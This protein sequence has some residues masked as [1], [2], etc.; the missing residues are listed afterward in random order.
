MATTIR[1][2]AHAVAPPPADGDGR[3][4]AGWEEQRDDEGSIYYYNTYTGVS[5]WALPGAAEGAA[6]ESEDCVAA[7]MPDLPA[8]VGRRLPLASLS[9]PSAGAVMSAGAKM[10]A[11]VNAAISRPFGRRARGTAA[12]APESEQLG[13]QPSASAAPGEAPTRPSVAPALSPDAPLGVTLRAAG[14]PLIPLPRV[15][16]LRSS[17]ELDASERRSSSDR[18]A[19]A[20]L[21]VPTLSA[22][23]RDSITRLQQLEQRLRLSTMAASEPRS[24]SASKDGEAPAIDR[25]CSTLTEMLRLAK[26]SQ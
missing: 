18:P 16:E 2:L 4:T 5:Q 12:D 20:D 9:L 24:R 15:T 25:S 6:D 3:L 22:E 19:S 23:D 7:D 8:S 17:V 10:S 21:L 14:A 13:A 11:D 1:N 26:V